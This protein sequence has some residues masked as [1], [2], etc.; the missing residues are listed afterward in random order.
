MLPSVDKNE[1]IFP[2]ATRIILH[3]H[4]EMQ[5]AKL[6][7]IIRGSVIPR[8]DVSKPSIVSFQLEWKRY[9]SLVKDRWVTFAS[10]GAR[11]IGRGKTIRKERMYFPWGKTKGT[12]MGKGKRGTIPW[13]WHVNG[14]GLD[15]HLPVYVLALCDRS[16][17]RWTLFARVSP[18]H[19]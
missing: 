18:P 14:K 3:T 2:S 4:R 17:Y 8:T 11:S 16:I 12:A 19:A 6:I 10:M 1:Q 15:T 7:L 13:W 5:L 9:E